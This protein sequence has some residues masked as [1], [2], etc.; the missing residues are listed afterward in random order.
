MSDLNA[1]REVL[2]RAVLAMLLAERQLAAESATAAD[3]AKREDAVSIAARDLTNA[4]DDSPPSARPKG[5]A[6][7]GDEDG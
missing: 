1:R 7:D 5:W 2:V 4:I 6:L 3:L